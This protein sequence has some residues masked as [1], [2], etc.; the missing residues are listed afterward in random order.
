MPEGERFARDDLDA[1]GVLARHRLTQ[2]RQIGSPRVRIR[3]EEGC[4]WLAG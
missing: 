4:P 1:G 2:T 3:A